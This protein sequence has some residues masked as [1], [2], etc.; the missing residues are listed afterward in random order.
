[1]TG[2]ILTGM[3]DDGVAGLA[4]I[5][6]RGGVAVIE[7]P[8]TALYPSMPRHAMARVDVDYVVPLRE[9]GSVVSHLAQTERDAIEKEEPMEKK[10]T[11]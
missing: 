2:V 7:D 4:E 9:V 10:V 1:M 11:R 8:E 6:R 5:K 3:L